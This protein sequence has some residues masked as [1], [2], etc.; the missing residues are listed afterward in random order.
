M[1]C[2]VCGAGTQPALTHNILGKYPCTYHQCPSCGFLQTE[3]PYW[4]DEAYSC[5][6]AAADT[7]LVGRNIAVAQT[8]SSI[9]YFLFDRNGAYLDVGGG[10]GLLTRLMR[11]VGFDFY[12]H[13]AKCDN[14]L[15]PGFEA[16]A[17]TAEFTAVTAFEVLEHVPDP[18][19]FL[20]ES[21]WRGKTRSIIFSTVLFDGDAPPPESWWYYAFATGQ[22]VSFFQP[23][24]LATIARMLGLNFYVG[25]SMHL[26][27]DRHFNARLYRA[28]T[29]PRL[30]VLSRFPKL[31]MESR[32]LDDHLKAM[33][34]GSASS[35]RLP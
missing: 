16:S 11:D 18:V 28:L 10:Y 2:R 24:T 8:L 33:A 32:T 15:A 20:R 14:L 1:K 19:R 5:P 34:R 13:D 4:L 6:I 29:A 17:T 26:L 21:M 30:R 7:G 12:W 25:R 27:T 23:R 9:L 22:H 35:G 3:D 31:L